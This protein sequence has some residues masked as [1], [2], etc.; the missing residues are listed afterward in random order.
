LLHVSKIAQNSQKVVEDDGL[1]A[2][3][4]FE[5]GT[6]FAIYNCHTSNKLWQF[7]V[8]HAVPIADETSTSFEGF[9]WP[10]HLRKERFAM[11]EPGEQ[12]IEKMHRH[13]KYHFDQYDLDDMPTLIGSMYRLYD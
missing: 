8:K 3:L 12:V 7:L 2:S 1:F 9:Q 6:V 11:T 10:E 13:L 4:D 5:S